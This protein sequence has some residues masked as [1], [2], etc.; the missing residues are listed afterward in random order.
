MS[1]YKL[2]PSAHIYIMDNEHNLPTS[3]HNLIFDL[4]DANSN[5]NQDWPFYL[6]TIPSADY[7]GIFNLSPN[8][9]LALAQQVKD[10]S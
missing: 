3:L 6:R 7:N 9:M 2:N 5:P 4:D 8:S 10:N 1:T